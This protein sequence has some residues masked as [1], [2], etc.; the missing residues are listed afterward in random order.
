[1]QEIENERLGLWL[2]DNKTSTLS[3]L[4]PLLI[5]PQ[6]LLL[7]LFAGKGNRWRRGNSTCPGLL[8]SMRRLL[9]TKI[10]VSRSR[11]CCSVTKGG[12]DNV[13]GA[14]TFGSK[15]VKVL[16]GHVLDRELGEVIGPSTKVLGLYRVGKT[17]LE[18]VLHCTRAAARGKAKLT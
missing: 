7:L 2:F 18:K 9:R 17:R 16:L 5:H 1:V 11:T 15:D 10:A 14:R 3:L 6:V 13:F 12:H 8:L 4:L